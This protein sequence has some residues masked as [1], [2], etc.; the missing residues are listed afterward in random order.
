[1]TIKIKQHA[2]EQNKKKR[3]RKQKHTRVRVMELCDRVVFID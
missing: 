1:M 3:N 2:L